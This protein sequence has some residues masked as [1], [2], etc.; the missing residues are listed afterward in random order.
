MKEILYVR[1]GRL[2]F[3]LW[4]VHITKKTIKIHLEYV[5][6]CYIDKRVCQEPKNRSSSGIIYAESGNEY[7]NAIVLIRNPFE[8]IYAIYAM[9]LDHDTAYYHFIEKG[10][11]DILH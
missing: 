11:I 5:P 10:N 1:N 3:R 9:I 6:Y 8:T 4:V 2:Y 7:E